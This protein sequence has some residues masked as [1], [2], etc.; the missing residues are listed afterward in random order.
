MVLAETFHHSSAPFPPKFKEEWVGRR[1]QHAALRGQKT[2][3]TTEATHFTSSTLV[4]RRP[5][6]FSLKEEPGGGQPAPLPEVGRSR[7]RLP[8]RADSRSCCAADGGLRGDAL[9]ILDRPIAEQVIEVSKFSCSPCPSRSPIPEPQSAEQLVEVPTVLSSLRIADQIVSTPVPLCRGKRRVQGFLPEQSSTAA[10]SVERI[11]ERI[12]EQFVDTS[13]CA[14]LWQGLASFACAADE[15]FAG[16][17]ALFPWKKVRSAGQ[18]VSARLGGHVS[19]STL[20]ARQLAR[21]GEPWT[22]TVPSCGL[23]C[24]LARLTRPTTGTDALVSHLARGGGCRGRLDG[25]EE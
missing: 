6:L 12:V 19:S 9:R 24:M 20:S 23:R 25:R 11:P 7:Y 2:A 18:E 1:E 13:P 14:G 3:R 15:Y 16:V 5:E 8:V 4:A 21:A 17:F 10:P 22:P